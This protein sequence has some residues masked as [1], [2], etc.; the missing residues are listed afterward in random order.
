MATDGGDPF[1]AAYE[2]LRSRVLSG[3]ALNRRLGLVVLLREG[4]AAWM[5]RG[6]AGPAPVEVEDNPHPRDE[7]HLLSDEIHAG[8][9]HVLASIA[10]ARKE[11]A[12]A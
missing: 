1:A 12:R 6:I 10:L 7:A 5:A 4:I 8:V 3:S 11:E 2:H 9:V